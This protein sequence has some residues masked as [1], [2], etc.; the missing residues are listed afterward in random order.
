[1]VARWLLG[2]AAP[3]WSSVPVTSLI[4]INLTLLGAVVLVPAFVAPSHAEK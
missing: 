1:M 3:T 4:R 2:E